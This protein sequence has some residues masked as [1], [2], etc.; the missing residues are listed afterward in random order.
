MSRG[1][2][3][4]RKR[5]GW[6]VGAI[7]LAL[8]ATAAGAADA[9][10]EVRIDSIEVKAVGRTA[11]VRMESD[12][13]ATIGIVNGAGG[14]LTDGEVRVDFGGKEK[15]FAL[16]GLDPQD[17]H[18]V[19]VSVD[20]EVRPGFYPLTVAA[21]GKVEGRKFETEVDLEL[22]VVPRPL[23]RKMPVLMWGGGDLDRLEEIGFTHH[24]YY[25]ANYGKIWEA[26]EPTEAGNPEELEKHA[27][28]LNEHL[29]RGIG[30]A[31]YLY[32][33]RWVA[34][35]EELLE[36]YG[37]VD[38]EG[39]PYEGKDNVCAS[40][41]EVQRY[42][43]DVGASIA[44]SFGEFPALQ[45]SL[46]HS[47]IRDGTSLCFHEHDRAAYRAFAGRDIPVEA[48]SKGG[49]RYGKIADFPRDR[50][51]ADDDPILKFYRW[52]WKEGDGWN[53]L[54]SQVDLG[55]KSTGREDLWTFFDPAV[56]VP[57]VWGSGGDVDI[58]SQWSYSYPDPLK[59][60]QAAD[61]LFAMA[62]GDAD[63]RVMK[64]TQVIWYRSQTAPKLPEEEA[65][66]AEWERELPDARFITISPDHMREA[67]WS[68][69]SRPI[70]G[71]M[72][73]GWGSLVKSEHGSYQYTNPETREVLK[74][75]V[76]TV[77]RPLGPTLLQVPDRPADVALLESFAAQVFAGRGTSG[78]GRSWEADAHLVL[79]WAQLQPQIVYDEKIARDG[80]EGIRVLVMPGCD[81]LTESVAEE[82]RAFQ[83]RGGLIV[84]DEQVAPVIMPDIV[85]SSYQ[86]TGKA[87]A[88]KVALQEKAAAL[89]RELDAFYRRY[90]DS[91]NPDVVVRTRQRGSA[92]YV[93]AVNDSRTFGEYV[94]HHGLVMEKGL[95][96]SARL[97]VDRR[98]GRVYDL[99]HHQEVTTETTADGLSF[100]VELGPGGGSVYMIVEQE[101]AEVKVEAPGKVRRGK[102]AKVEVRVVDGS[103]KAIAAVI[104]VEV[105]ILDGEGKP[106]EFS[107]YYGASDGELS[108]ELDIAENDLPG[109]WTIRLTELAS[110]RS[111]ERKL[112]VH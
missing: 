95:P 54:H 59:I 49:I 50:I 60:G 6:T 53:E 105:E 86:R 43:Y 74:E 80:L 40:F 10:V 99:L 88:D 33:G 100:D 31:V 21:S 36:Q 12:A 48:V 69:I 30:A 72:Y 11:F 14:M 24:L 61:E 20:T 82:I 75:L 84:A 111:A 35:S 45:A 5:S 65:E 106:A 76:N 77:V 29:A 8:L 78:W 44:R 96:A 98:S 17:R 66:R 83:D 51:V 19:E 107:G 37:R 64:M 58:V 85:L 23:P 41:P 3:I 15:K 71:I 9:E 7:L 108:L 104:P 81:V 92:D 62:A 47:E 57:S 97:S 90:A 93:F 110:G 38:R 73:H 22:V 63:Q 52:F 109:D 55:L 26:E 102:R 87:E 16:P 42:A 103:G 70:R 4:M 2:G 27:S 67:F 1:R 32:P 39:L 101:I 56:R 68:K 94:G 34:R 79:Q 112:K 13:R 46:V 28:V 18:T 25:M 91:S 89:R